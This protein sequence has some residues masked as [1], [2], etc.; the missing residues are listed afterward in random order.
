MQ[1]QNTNVYVGGNPYGTPTTQSY[2]PAQQQNQQAL[3]TDYSTYYGTAGTQQAGY[4]QTAYPQNTA[5]QAQQAAQVPTGPINETYG[6][7]EA[8]IVRIDGET[9]R[10]KHGKNADPEQVIQQEQR[11]LN[12]KIWAASTEEIQRAQKAAYERMQVLEAHPSPSRCDRPR[13]IQASTAPGSEIPK[14]RLHPNLTSNL[15]FSDKSGKTWF[16]GGV[17]FPP[18][19]S[20]TGNETNP[21]G[22]TTLSVAP[23][24]L[25]AQGNFTV[26][27]QGT[28][29]PLVVEYAHSNVVDCVVEVRLDSYSPE[30]LREARQNDMVAP[31]DVSAALSDDELLSIG[32]GMKPDGGR[33]MKASDRNVRVWRMKDGT[34]IVRTRYDIVS[35]AP[36]S[37]SQHPDGTKIFRVKSASVYSYRFNDQYQVFTVSR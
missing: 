18:N 25:A 2:E 35:P 26:E 13:V 14:I 27:L 16:L 21:N 10:Y 11:P 9:I 12:D 29:V 28:P 23:K 30:T 4:Q 22:V 1:G 24:T 32:M 6:V 17:V 20:V 31:T 34:S 5:P 15:V 3:P 33:E 36:I 8:N 19:I 7:P 37:Q